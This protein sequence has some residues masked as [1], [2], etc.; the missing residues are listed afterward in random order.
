MARVETTEIETGGG[1]GVPTKRAPVLAVRLGRGRTGGTT[2]LDFLIQR[3]RNQG[4]E[5]IVA[6]GDR[7]NADLAGLHP[8]AMQPPTDETGDVKEWITAVLIRMA[9]TGRSV[10]LD[11]GGGD[12]VLSEYGKD[13]ALTEFCAEIGAQ[14][15]ALLCMGPDPS[16]F[17]HV[18]S[19]VRAGYF[20]PG[21]SVLVLN[22][23]LV[24][25]N[26]T[27]AAAF[28]PIVTRGDF[29]ELVKAGARPIYLPALACMDHLRTRGLGFYAAIAG[30]RGTSDEVMDP[31]RRFMV[32]KWIARL[33]RELAEVGVMDW[34]P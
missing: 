1:A 7:R 6:D 21:R 32:K 13:L 4:R 17:E 26:R 34:L 15:L 5:I 10:A 33:E 12:R 22:E 29:A 25:A 2:L 28:E 31:V 30:E 8:G 18:L 3:A 24:P 14:P 11:L 19:L 27:A 16:D 23:N 9:E 20:A